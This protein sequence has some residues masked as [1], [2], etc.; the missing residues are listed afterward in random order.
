VVDVVRVSK[1]I[2]RIGRKIKGAAPHASPRF[3]TK[4]KAT[5]DA[6]TNGAC[7]RTDGHWMALETNTRRVVYTVQLLTTSYLLTP[8]PHSSYKRRTPPTGILSRPNALSPTT[9]TPSSLLG[10]HW[11]IENVR[12]CFNR[13][14]KANPNPA[15]AMAC[16]K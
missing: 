12:A 15:L 10:H 13:W 5:R 16:F 4:E 14:L 11:S 2:N 3:T 1:G 6:P 8:H 9:G 7:W